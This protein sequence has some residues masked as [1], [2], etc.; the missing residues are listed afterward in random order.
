MDDI[1]VE[2]NPDYL[3]ITA[4]LD[5]SGS[6][7]VVNV[8][9][10]LKQDITEMKVKVSLAAKVKGEFREVYPAEDFNPCEG[11]VKDEFVRYAL[12]QIEKF[13]NLTIACPLK[14]VIILRGEFY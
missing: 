13:G 14:A 5:R 12:D 7:P 8:A 2:G 1:N 4:G 6:E 3:D 11:E 9:I 10:N